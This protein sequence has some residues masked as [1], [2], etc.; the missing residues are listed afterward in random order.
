MLQFEAWRPGV[1]LCYFQ[2]FVDYSVGSG[3]CFTSIKRFGLL[4][5][6]LHCLGGHYARSNSQYQHV[7]VEWRLED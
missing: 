5:G 3:F 6:L 7:Q 1:L 2:L 4:Y